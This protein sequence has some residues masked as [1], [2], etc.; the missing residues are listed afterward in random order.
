MRS[1]LVWVNPLVYLSPWRIYQLRTA[2][3]NSV[4]VFARER[5]AAGESISAATA[6]SGLL[7]RKE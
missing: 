3:G 2:E 1:P 7:V 5:P 4:I 6:F